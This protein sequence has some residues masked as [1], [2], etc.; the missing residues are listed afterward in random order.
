[1]LN[2]RSWSWHE[3][4]NA[5]VLAYPKALH[6]RESE[7]SSIGIAQLQATGDLSNIGK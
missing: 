1:M 7:G 3:F 4:V 6:F 2:K 5:M